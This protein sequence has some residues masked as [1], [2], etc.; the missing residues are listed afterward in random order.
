MLTAPPP[1]RRAVIVVLDGLR[2][3]AIAAFR[4]PNLERLLAVSAATLRGRTVRPS[5]T[6]AAMTSLAT[7]LR[8]E[9][10]GIASDRLV[11]PPRP[12]GLD[13]LPAVVRRAGH[14]TAGWFGQI[15]LA[16]QFF[17]S[18]A[19][20]LLNVQASFAGENALAVAGRAVRALA[21]RAHGLHVCHWLDA[22]RAGHAHGWM[23]EPYAAA[24][25]TLD[26]ALGVVAAACGAPESPETLLVVMADHGG[27]GVDPKNH[28]ADHPIDYT[29][30]I[31][32]CG[33]GV[34]PGTLL[35]PI[36][37]L[38]VPATVAWALGARVPE[39]W[40]GR[41]LVEAFVEAESRA[42]VREKDRV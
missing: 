24:A 35:E 30:P 12:A 5:V 22:D 21:G 40:E 10:H 11:L 32:L 37:L 6:A 13:P 26:A 29:I 25:R 1:I 15:P 18:R 7:G 14:R 23:S 17:A 28:E 9:R 3:D 36:S 39:S 16:M 33:G 34:Q 31:L 2:P 41:V 27:G 19:A 4:L 20:G 38:D 8:P 42:T